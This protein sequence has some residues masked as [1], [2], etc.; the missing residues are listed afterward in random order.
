MVFEEEDFQPVVYGYRLVPDVT[1]TRAI[2][3]L[4]EVEEDLNRRLKSM[5]SKAVE[6]KTPEIRTE[7][8][9]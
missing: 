7:V 8:L 1:E 2:G 3:M 5:R 9:L 6:E 4:R